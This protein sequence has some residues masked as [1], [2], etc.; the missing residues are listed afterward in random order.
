MGASKAVSA[1]P[2]VVC[3]YRWNPGLCV[4]SDL[5]VP[6]SCAGGRAARRAFFPEGSCPASVALG[7][8][9]TRPT[10]TE[11]SQQGPGRTL[12]PLEGHT[13]MKVGMRMLSQAERKLVGIWGLGAFTG[14]IGMLG[15]G[16]RTV[17]GCPAGSSREA[18]ALGRKPVRLYYWG[19]MPRALKLA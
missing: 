14:S 8:T 1:L 3:S 4:Q 11:S 12:H 16:P 18:R 2:G 9:N 17:T 15:P 5:G 6:S 19:L 7:C 10:G 13:R